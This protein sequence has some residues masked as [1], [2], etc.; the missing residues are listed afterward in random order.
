MKRIKLFFLPY[1]GGTASVYL[2]WRKC[3]DQSI[4][5]KPVELAGRGK[6][7]NEPLYKR[8]DE[9]AEDI[10]K[11]M[12]KE[13]GEGKYA[14]FGH[15]MGAILA[16][17]IAK[18]IN[19]AN[20]KKPEHIFFSGRSALDSLAEPKYIYTLNDDQFI[21]SIIKYGG[22]NKEVFENDA[23]KA[24]FLPILRADFSMVERYKFQNNNFRLGCDITILNGTEDKLV[25]FGDLKNW[26]SLTYGSC[27]FYEF[28]EGHFFINKYKQEICK[29][30]S[31]TLVDKYQG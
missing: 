1:A 14:I 25:S 12:S 9:A 6:R 21:K 17:E 28:T 31:E 2:S 20:L 11:V 5:I 22:T 27:K 30:I 19:Q 23:L 26:E 15:S 29:I 8:V 18:K 4:D 13:I 24:I 16:F 3:L 10:F 7:I